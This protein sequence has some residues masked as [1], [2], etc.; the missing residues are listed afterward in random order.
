[1]HCAPVLPF[2][3][4][5]S[6]GRRLVGPLLATALLARPVA[7]YNHDQHQGIV[8]LAYRAMVAAA[9]EKGLCETPIDFD[10]PAGPASLRDF[11][12]SP[13]LD[14]V[15]G[16]EARWN[17]MLDEI[18]YGIQYLHGLDASLA[19]PLAGCPDP[20]GPGNTLGQVQY[21]VDRY[22]D[23][24]DPDHHSACGIPQYPDT[25]CTLP[26]G[27]CDADSIW[28]RLSRNDHTG[29]V[30]GYWAMEP[31]NDASVS[32][33]GFKP[34]SALGG[35]AFVDAVDTALDGA[36][37][38]LAVPLVCAFHFLSDG[39]FDCLHD[40]KK[41]AD[42]AV[43]YDELL[44]LVPVLGEIRDAEAY[45]GLW[46]FQQSVP[47]ASNTC[48]DRQ[49]LLYEEAGPRLVPDAVDLGIMIVSDAL[50]LTLNY[51]ESTGP[52]RFNITDPGD[53]DEA[54]CHR[55]RSE[56]EFQTLGHTV[57]S[58][59]DNMALYGWKRF[60]AAP[61]AR[62]L[63]WP[64]HAI[65]DAVAPHHAA[66]TTGWGHRPYEDAAE[67]YW[68]KVL[69]IENT[70]DKKRPQYEQLRR[71]LWWALYYARK[72]DEERATHPTGAPL[73]AV[74]IRAFITQI[75]ADTLAFTTEKDTGAPLWP[76]D[77]LLSVPY[78]LDQAAKTQFLT[79]A[80]G[81]DF[82]IGRTRDMIERGAGATIAFLSSVWRVAGDP[83]AVPPLC[84]TGNPHAG[85]LDCTPGYCARGGCCIPPVGGG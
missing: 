11:Y 28:R 42:N 48:D 20:R 30:L 35:G 46:H 47:G 1:M 79:V 15:D 52:K 50:G 74:P 10:G 72:L 24:H 25:S 71:V 75:A 41:L 36:A 13:C 73:N 82:S 5:P 68:N 54:S 58:P 44:S 83:P 16:C 76:F 77:P 67:I 64:L 61:S 17:Q 32:V 62:E 53:G 80:Y 8:A 26:V 34:T 33:L 43:P 29:D 22:Y 9:D 60:A 63:A 39:D 84:D 59:I 69:Y 49:G 12:T 78:V 81:S 2:F 56:W 14:A 27:M 66:G 51:D 31:D 21:G 65:G 7:A 6:C 85:L 37:L 55:D 3:R 40:A 23:Q 57:F 19:A 45:G 4:R 18:D 70:L 38:A